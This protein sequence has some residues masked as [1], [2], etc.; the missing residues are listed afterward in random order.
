MV[1]HVVLLVVTC[2]VWQYVWTY[3]MTKYTNMAEGEEYR[4][5]TKKLLLSIFVP[6]YLVYWTYI[7]AQRIDKMAA[8]KGVT[9]NI[10]LLSTLM[11]ALISFLAPVFMQERVNAIE[12]ADV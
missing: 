12:K 5:P 8:A 3:Y 6:F 2:G 11:S 7:T 9:S 10:T 1:M 4:D